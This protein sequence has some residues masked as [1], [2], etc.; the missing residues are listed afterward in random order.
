MPTENRFQRAWDALFAGV[1]R[2]STCH[3]D[4]EQLQPHPDGGSGGICEDCA[5]ALTHKPSR[6]A[7]PQGA[8]RSAREIRT[9]SQILESIAMP[10]LPDVDLGS[11]MEKPTGRANIVAFVII[12][13]GITF[14]TG[15][16]YL[17]AKIVH[18]IFFGFRQL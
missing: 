7:A 5:I 6:R 8:T 11:P 3:R 13:I 18:L 1:N 14:A 10:P 2:C 4:D 15:G 9:E 17:S 16:I 12:L